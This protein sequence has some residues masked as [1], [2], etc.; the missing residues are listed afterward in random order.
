MK[1]VG[2]KTQPNQRLSGGKS[3]L[4][5]SSYP[6]WE[7]QR[8]LL[9]V[10]S[11]HGRER[12]FA[13]IQQINFGNN[14]S[15]SPPPSTIFIIPQAILE[16]HAV[17]FLLVVKPI[18]HVSTP[19][20]TRRLPATYSLVVK[21]NVGQPYVLRRNVELGHAAIFGRIP[22]ELVVGPFLKHMAHLQTST[23]TPSSETKDPLSNGSR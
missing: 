18:F 7:R 17:Q 3:K 20:Q 16:V 5:C 11:E 13:T 22:H 14:S 6:C 10:T 8:Q 9:K 23:W 15:P 2:N 21:N 1:M 19:N 4:C 12:A